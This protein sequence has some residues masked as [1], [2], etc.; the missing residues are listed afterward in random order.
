MDAARVFIGFDQ[1]EA[2]TYHVCCQSII[3]NSTIP[4]E[5]HPL[6]GNHFHNFDG[7]KDG[8]N[9]FTVSRYLV[10][11]LCEFKGKAIFIDGDMVFDADIAELWAVADRNSYRAVSVVKHDYKTRSE[12]KYVGSKLES[13]NIDYPRKNWSSVMVWD[14]GHFSNRVLTEDFVRETEPSYLH[15]LQWL[16]DDDIGSLFPTWNYLVGEE[17]PSS[18]RNYHYTLGVPGI[19]HYAD[20]HASWHWHQKLLKTLEC[21]GEDP[22][23]VVTR[24][25]KRIGQ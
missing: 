17:A 21:A 4:V 2:I 19:A 3:E 24:A 20:D 1:R 25:A 16:K 8:T 22:V 7:Q 18:A 9:A 13:K 15:R 11:L 12:R 10:P 5:F 14:C 6:A 23:D